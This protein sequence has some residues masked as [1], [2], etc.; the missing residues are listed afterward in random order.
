MK[1]IKEIDDLS[2]FDAW[3]EAVSTKDRIIE[4]GKGEEFM[5]ALEDVYPNGISDSDLNDLLWFEESWCLDLVGLLIRA[6]DVIELDDF[7]EKIDELVEE[8]IEEKKEEGIEYSSNQ[9]NV[10]PDDFED[11]IQDYL[12]D[13]DFDTEN[14]ALDNWLFYEGEYLIKKA[15]EECV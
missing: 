10:E 14:K 2:N 7:Q 3:S 13:H 9:F 5:S 1:V 8:F 11:Y 4:A 15:I 12:Y 6:E